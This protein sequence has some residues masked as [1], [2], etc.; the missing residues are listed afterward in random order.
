MWDF[1]IGGTLAIMMRTWP[2]IVFRMVVYFGIA[3]AYIVATGTG[4]GI[5]FG[6]GHIFADDGG[7]ATGAIWGGIFGFGFV[8]V[9]LYWLREYVLY[10]VKA[11][12][13]AVMVKLIDGQDIPDGRG[14]I[15]WAGSQVKE[16]FV[17]TNVLFAVD[18]LVK[19]VVRVITGLVTTIGNFLP[20]PGL[21]GIVSF[22]NTVI[23][24]SLTYVD[25]VVLGY[26]MRIGSNNPYETAQDALVLYAQNAGR[27][28]KNAVWLSVFMWVLSIVAFLV[29][30]APAAAILFFFPGQLG[31]WSFV[32]A[33]ILAWAF[34]AALL[35]PFAIAALMSVY[36]KAIEGQRPDP[37]WRGKLASASNRFRELGDKA[38]AY[39][40]GTPAGAVRG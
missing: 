26:N 9:L 30:L 11:G 23:R 16:R 14:Q 2:F 31:G 24:I 29:M 5:G 22:V 10:I 25:E 1:S 17:E 36:F 21:Q 4:A 37:E 6:A 20:I 3:F 18:Q 27:L 13:I 38:A 32:L 8:S 19:G 35:E 7:P 34:K 15:A 33:I 12:H 40:R 39:V 28:V